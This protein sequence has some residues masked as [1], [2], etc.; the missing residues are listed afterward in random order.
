MIEFSKVH[1]DVPTPKRAH[2]TDAGVDLTAWSI[3]TGEGQG[4]DWETDVISPGVSRV[5]G[6]GVR[7]AVPE[8]YVG[9]L[10]ARSSLGVK[11]RLDVANGTGV[12]DAG[13]RGEVKVCLRNTGRIH[14][15]L[16]RGERVAQLV[17]VPCDRE[18]WVEV[19]HLDNTE[20]GEGGYGSTGS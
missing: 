2:P 18:E 19:A 3:D 16:K 5:F 8:G 9:L 13:Y 4:T 1:P 17:V 20:R 14:A 10:F 12:I 11:R 7:V 15:R 6:T